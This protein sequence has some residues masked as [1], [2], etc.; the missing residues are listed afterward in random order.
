[1]GFSPSTDHSFLIS[2]NLAKVQVWLKPNKLS[3]NKKNHTI[4][5][6]RIGTKLKHKYF[7]LIA[8]A[9]HHG[10]M[11]VFI[12]GKLKFNKHVNELYWSLPSNGNNDAYLTPGTGKF[13]PE[14]VL[15]IYLIKKN[16]S[17]RNTRIS[18]WSNCSLSK[19]TDIKSKIINNGSIRCEKLAGKFEFKPM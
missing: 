6:Y 11:G 16:L 2:S 12:D 19:T 13:Y 8:R 3:V 1:M 5:Y 10:L 14:F 4:L 9:N 15:Y 18:I 7:E 17:K